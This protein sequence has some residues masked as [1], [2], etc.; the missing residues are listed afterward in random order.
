MARRFSGWVVLSAALIAVVSAQ[1]DRAI[2]IG[3]LGTRTL[4]HA[5]NCYPEK[6][7]WA[8][9]I[10][11]ALTTSMLPIA[12]EQ[13]IMWVASTPDKPGRSVVAHDT[14][15][16]GDEPTLDRYFFDRMRPL[17]ERALTENRRETWPL[18]ILHLDFKTNEREHHRYVWDLLGRYEGWLT[19]APRTPHAS[20]PQALTHGPLLVL[21][22][23]GE[24]QERV[25]FDEVAV[26]SRL[27]LFG[28]VPPAR[29]SLPEDPAA[30]ASLIARQPVSSLVPSGATNYRRWTNHSWAVIEEGGQPRAGE[31]TTAENRR[32]KALGLDTRL[33]LRQPAGSGDALACSDRGR[34]GSSR[35]RSIRGLRAGTSQRRG[36]EVN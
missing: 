8:D 2:H 1:A 22:E 14:P 23:N 3:R 11:R 30:R 7:Q 32:L 35:D 6:G 36:S 15:P 28:T 25:F 34:S 10:D 17:L 9:R 18:Y 26:G 31:W 4:L 33:Q 13:D 19:T 29:V 24:G 20:P 12:I 21:T 5:H 27:R 16:T